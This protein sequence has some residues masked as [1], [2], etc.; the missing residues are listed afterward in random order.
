MNLLDQYG[1]GSHFQLAAE[2]KFFNY[3]VKLPGTDYR[4][5]IVLRDLYASILSG[6]LYH[7]KGFE[8]GMPDKVRDYLG[9]WDEHLSYELKPPREGRSIC[10]YIAKTKTAT[11]LRAYMDWVMR[12]YYAP[13]FA[14]WA[15]SEEVPEMRE[16]TKVVCYEDLMS[17]EE[18]RDLKAVHSVVDFFFDHAPPTPWE[19][20]P[21]GHAKVES[22]Y[23]GGHSTTNDRSLAQ[24]ESLIQLIKNL[25][26][27]FYHG[28]IAWLN[29]INPCG[30]K[31]AQ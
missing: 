23:K 3:N 4:D 15:M 10:Q 14:H 17:K 27:K 16:R 18:D 21:P 9:E 28:E 20:T 6:Y 24:K 5:V 1:K 11:G 19:G 31:T 2:P 13:I 12:Y 7:H 8:C 25:D 30:P 22:G 26:Q 29:S